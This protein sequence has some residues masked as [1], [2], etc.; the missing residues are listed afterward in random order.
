LKNDTELAAVLNMARMQFNTDKVT[1]LFKIR[2]SDVIFN[3]SFVIFNVSFVELLRTG[4]ITLRRQP[5][6]TYCND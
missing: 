2:S 3:F 5:D 1:G 4:E 6:L